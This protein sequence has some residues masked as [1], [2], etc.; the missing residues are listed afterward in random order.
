M[1]STLS[2]QA[3]NHAVEEA[4]QFLKGKRAAAKDVIRIKMGIEEAL[5][6]Y[7]NKMGEDAEFSMDMGISFG[8]KRIRLD[9]PG[10]M[11]DPFIS[12]ELN[13]EEDD[14]MRQTLVRMG[15]LP[16]WQYH[17]GSNRILFTLYKTRRPEW[18]RL[19]IAVVSAVILGFFMKM[20]PM[21]ARTLILEDVV[22]PLLAKFLGFLN[23]VAGPMIFL[24]VIWGV[25]SI[26]D[27][28]T[29]SVMGKKLG[30]KYLFYLCLFTVLAALISLA[31]FDL[32]FG[33]FRGGGELSALYQMV[34]DIIP[35]NL[36]V[37]FARGNTLQ[38]LFE[39]IV[40]GIAM[41][42]IRQ[43]TRVVA[44]LAEQ[45]SYIIN[46]I[47]GV[48]SSLVPEFVFGSLFM[49]IATSE[50][51]ALAVGGIFFGMTVAVCIL[52]MLIQGM[53]ACVKIKMSPSDL[54]RK[55]LP[56]FVISITTASSSAAFPKNME[57]CSKELGIDK[58]MV[59]FGVPFGQVI[60]KP[61]VT[62][63]FWFAAISVAS[64]SGTEISLTW[65]ITAILMS[66]ILSAA[67]PPV[68]GGMSASFAILFSQLG[69]PSTDLAMILTLTSV[70]DFVATATNIFSG[71]CVLA[72]VSEE[73][74]FR[75]PRET[76]S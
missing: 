52:S 5:L 17:H 1:K 68:P 37:P 21:D 44:D 29:F 27:T 23:A 39:G 36:F 69:L 16:R 59:S 20:M 31:V 35:D 34:L 76:I 12:T 18:E 13:S 33:D 24:S 67:A 66:V 63:L 64:H 8:K 53:H 15:E 28:T 9:I 38:I 57:I 54:W 26:G 14:F 30:L 51:D 2:L 72:I 70:L 3:I 65:Y 73:I 60:Y 56:T 43:E 71:Q 55:T 4:D 49:I 50:N 11:I 74:G 7:Q 48:I 42:L 75:K 22:S 47:M 46:G 32:R 6:T 61:A 40:V 25:Y 41:L 62:I 58:K 10:A 19:L 45:M